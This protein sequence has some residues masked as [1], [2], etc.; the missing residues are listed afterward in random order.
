MFDLKFYI[1]Y[2]SQTMTTE[3]KPNMSRLGQIERSLKGFQ[4]I[5]GDSSTGAPIIE[6]DVRDGIE[7]GIAKTFRRTEGNDLVTAVLNLDN[8]TTDVT[9]T[10]AG[11]I[12]VHMS[13]LIEEQG[14]IVRARVA[15]TLLERPDY[16]E[17]HDRVKAHFHMLNT[18]ISSSHS[19]NRERHKIERAIKK[20]QAASQQT[21]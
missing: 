8:T 11:K 18:P 3:T 16:S 7:R 2:Y 15:L 9:Q 21:A 5:V 14:D 4:K 10:L 20:A 12:G 1:W 19:P 13:G 17:L 6:I